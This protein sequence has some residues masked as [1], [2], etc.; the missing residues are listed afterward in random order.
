M[1]YNNQVHDI[2]T[3]LTSPSPPYIC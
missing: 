1:V 3:C 2:V